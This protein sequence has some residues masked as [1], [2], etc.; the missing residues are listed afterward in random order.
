MKCFFPLG[1]F[2]SIIARGVSMLWLQVHSVSNFSYIGTMWS[3]LVASLSLAVFICFS[4]DT[5][6]PLYLCPAFKYNI[7]ETV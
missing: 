7:K 5:Y 4:Q 2:A 3:G 1:R 6:C